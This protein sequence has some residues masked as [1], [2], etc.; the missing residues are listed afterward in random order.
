MFCKWVFVTGEQLVKRGL[1]KQEDEL[2]WKVQEEPG[3]HERDP[4]L[5]PLW[6]A[7]LLPRRRPPWRLKQPQSRGAFLGAQ[8]HNVVPV[9]WKNGFLLFDHWPATTPKDEFSS[10][11][12]KVLCSY[13]TVFGASKTKHFPLK[14]Q[15]SPAVQGEKNCSRLQ[16]KKLNQ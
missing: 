15:P 2:H 5:L 8:C 16:G 3:H 9:N 7:C 1:S 13:V 4:V 12:S 11:C 10:A 14:K 6:E